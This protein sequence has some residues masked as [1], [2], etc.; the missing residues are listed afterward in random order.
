MFDCFL[1]LSWLYYELRHAAV[2]PTLCVGA[3]DCPPGC[4]RIDTDRGH[5]LI[6]GRA[7]GDVDKVVRVKCC[8][9]PT[10]SRKETDQMEKG[11]REES[12]GQ[13]GLS[14]RLGPE[15]HTILTMFST[16]S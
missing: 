9:V 16:N 10:Q 14:L 15:A 2:S 5:V 6:F 8:I 1:L 12:V 4:C 7:R 3:N 11:G 13:S